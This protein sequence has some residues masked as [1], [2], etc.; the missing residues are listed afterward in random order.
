MVRNGLCVSVLQFLNSTRLTNFINNKKKYVV[1]SIVLDV[2]ASE[3][4]VPD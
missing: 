2:F 4:W 1:W 3:D